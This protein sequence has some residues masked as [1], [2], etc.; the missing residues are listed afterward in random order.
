LDDVVKLTAIILAVGALGLAGCATHVARSN[1]VEAPP[2]RI[3]LKPSDDAFA[4]AVKSLTASEQATLKKGLGFSVDTL[5]ITPTT[6]DT[7]PWSRKR[8]DTPVR[9]NIAD[10]VRFLD[11]QPP[12]AGSARV[13]IATAR[14]YAGLNYGDAT[15]DPVFRIQM[16]VESTNAGVIN[17][18][19][20][21]VG[22]YV[23]RDTDEF[24]NASPKLTQ[25]AQI[26]FMKAFLKAL[27][28]INEV[29]EQG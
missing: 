7:M 2:P 15:F 13:N 1:A 6:V 4:G 19:G 27:L 9:V 5:I 12:L 8:P 23:S 18:S 29:V 14:V 17:I 10:F 22:P 16:E 26:A 24:S 21:G 28:K 3:V 20:F 25:S 11:L